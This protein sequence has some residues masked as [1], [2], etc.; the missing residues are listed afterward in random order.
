MR[1]DLIEGDERAP[2]RTSTSHWRKYGIAYQPRGS[3]RRS[4]DS[5]LRRRTSNPV[6]GEARQVTPSTWIG[7]CARCAQPKLCSGSFTNEARRACP[8]T[9]VYRLLYQR[10]LYLLAYGKLYRNHGALTPGISPETV[11]AM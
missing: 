3:W 8:K 5:S 9:R 1:N 2:K 10:D 6:H 7:R 4:L 11:D